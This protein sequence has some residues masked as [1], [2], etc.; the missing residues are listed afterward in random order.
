M[1]DVAETRGDD[2]PEPIFLQG[3]SCILA[4]GAATEVLPGQQDLCAL[5]AGLIQHKLRI[6]WPPRAILPRHA[7]VEVTPL[8]EQVDPEAGPT[9]RLEKLLRNDRVRIHVRPVDWRDQPVDFRESE[10]HATAGGMN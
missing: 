10:H 3:P 7:R 1:E 2:H 6:A 9:Y 8:I 5:E 4:A